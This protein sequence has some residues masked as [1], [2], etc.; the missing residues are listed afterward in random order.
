MWSDIMLLVGLIV[1]RS[2]QAVR[3]LHESGVLLHYEDSQSNLSDLYF[4]DPEWLC[5]MMAKIVTHK[6]VNGFLQL[7]HVL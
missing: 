5:S 2:L 1:Y 6:E 7:V 4:L 3:F